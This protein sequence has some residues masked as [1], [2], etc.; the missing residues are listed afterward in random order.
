MKILLKTSII[1]TTVLYVFIIYSCKKE[2]NGTIIKK[3]KVTGY[4]QKGPYIK[5]TSIQLFELNNSLEQT[6]NLFSSQITNNNGSFEINSISLSSNYV[7]FKA[8]GYYFNENSGDISPSQLSL[9]A[10]SDITDISSANVN[11][12]THLEKERLKYLID[13]GMSFS[14]AKDSAQQ[15]IL[16]IF[17]FRNNSIGHS[18]ELNIYS[19]NEGDAI[20]L[21]ISLILQGDRSI[22][23]ITDLLANISADIQLDGTLDS[24][25]ILT[26]LRNSTKNLDIESILTNIYERYQELEI[27][28]AI[29]GF[30]KYIDSFLS[31]T[32]QKPSVTT[33]PATNITISGVTLTGVINANDLT[34]NV[35]FEY[36]TDTGYGKTIMTTQSPING[37]AETIVNEEIVGL[38]A[39]ITYHYRIKATNDLG[40][41][42]GDDMI[43]KM[44]NSDAINDSEN[45]FYNI[46]TIGTQVWMADNLKTSKFNDGS[47]IPN[48]ITKVVWST[49]TTPGY[50]WPDND[51]TSYKHIYGALYNWYTVNTGNLCPI[52]WHVPTDSEWSVLS[53][54]LGGED[55]AGG[56]LKESG[57]THWASP[58]TLAT[59]ETGFTALPGGVRH[60]D[61]FFQIPGYY[62]Y[63]WSSSEFL[64]SDAWRLGLSNTTAGIHRMYRNKG[65]GYSVRCLKD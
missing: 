15:Q 10:L 47:T 3:E 26:S 52:G 25:F 30:E 2:T 51:E 28:A 48:V 42:Y 24:K 56:K 45:N 27:S 43:F 64:S 40:T 39:G 33:L 55:V 12:L 20:L 60:N 44:Y 49:L 54:Y 21:A 17:G 57:T 36:G 63:W 23:D 61:G 8:I 11:I 6:G 13:M 59:N 22:S 37:N 16:A 35:F 5:G 31:F 7:E 62:G 9:S 32:G 1:L 14:E 58:N 65:Y 53:T 41:T 18:E 38:E 29:P 19:D 34:S 50:C 4:V 46:V